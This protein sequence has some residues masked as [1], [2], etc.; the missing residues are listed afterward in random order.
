MTLPRIGHALRH[1][2]RSVSGASPAAS[3][4]CL[5]AQSRVRLCLACELDFQPLPAS[6][7]KG[8]Q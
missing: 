2:L 1:A 3:A 4:L 6:I 5:H 7:Y 8:E